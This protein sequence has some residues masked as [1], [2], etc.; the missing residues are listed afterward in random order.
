M[1]RSRRRVWLKAVAKVAAAIGEVVVMVT[2]VPAALTEMSNALVAVFVVGVAES[3]TIT[4]KFAVTAAAGVP[5]LITAVLSIK[6]A[7][8]TKTE[9]DHLNG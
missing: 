5:E 8:G 2:G 7:W 4:V 3:V 9:I 1:P 6:P